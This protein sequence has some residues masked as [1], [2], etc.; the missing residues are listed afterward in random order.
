MTD[1]KGAQV[2]G[3]TLVYEG[4]Q[5]QGAELSGTNGYP[6]RALGDSLIWIGRLRGNVIVRYSL[7]V[8]A[9]SEN[10]LRLLG[11][12]ELWITPAQ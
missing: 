5:D 2:P 3:T 6:Y 9:L 12:A 11:T 7:R 1:A 8:A 10:S 4:E